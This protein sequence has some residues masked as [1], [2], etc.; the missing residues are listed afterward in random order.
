MHTCLLNTSYTS[1]GGWRPRRSPHCIHAEA[2]TLA[3]ARARRARSGVRHSSP[4]DC[5]ICVHQ[6]CTHSQKLQMLNTAT[7]AP[8]DAPAMD[9]A[10][11]ASG[12][13]CCTTSNQQPSHTACPCSGALDS[14]CT[15]SH[16]LIRGRGAAASG[17]GTSPPPPPQVLSLCV[18][19]CKGNDDEAQEQVWL[20]VV[21]E[22]P[23]S[24]PQ[25]VAAAGRRQPGFT[26]CSH[27]HMHANATP[28]RPSSWC[29]SCPSQQPP[30][31][32]DPPTARP[33]SASAA[34]RPQQACCTRRSCSTS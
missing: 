29:S 9:G 17:N 18:C 20:G 27:T 10:A 22:R 15:C 12:A 3:A 1:R 6:S 19:Q 34:R 21:V 25:A 16:L 2:R 33:A 7:A 23:G 14:G 28:H 13:G 32:T 5:A 24:P 26:L 30:S 8:A 31:A 11:L 4:R